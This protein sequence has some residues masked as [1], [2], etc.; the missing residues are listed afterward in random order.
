M[1]V[2]PGVNDFF[3]AVE[4]LFVKTFDQGINLYKDIM[5]KL[6]EVGKTPF[7]LQFFLFLLVLR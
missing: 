4:Q 7:F 3:L 1:M 6:E 5:D 2:V